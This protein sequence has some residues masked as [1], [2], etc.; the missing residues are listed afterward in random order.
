VSCRYTSPP[1]L[2]LCLC[3]Y[4]CVLVQPSIWSAGGRGFVRRF[5]VVGGSPVYQRGGCGVPLRCG[6]QGQRHRRRAE[7]PRHAAAVAAVAGAPA[8]EGAAGAV[9][10]GVGAALGGARGAWTVCRPCCSVWLF[11]TLGGLF[12]HMA[13]PPPPPPLPPHASEHTRAHA[14]RFSLRCSAVS[15]HL[16]LTRGSLDADP[17]LCF[18]TSWMAAWWPAAACCC[19]AG[20]SFLWGE[21]D[22]LGGSVERPPSL[23]SRWPQARSAA[24]PAGEGAALPAAWRA[25]PAGAPAAA[26]AA[27]RYRHHH[28]HPGGLVAS[29]RQQQPQ[30]SRRRALAC[31]HRSDAAQPQR[32]ALQA[33]W[34]VHRV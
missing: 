26:A 2:C 6:T 20:R 7:L 24:Q 31:A 28:H 9:P 34:C 22:E 15:E 12:V 10:A 8:G 29:A 13:A 3:P 27:A 14:W 32:R 18:L 30:P 1:P 21:L 25:L 11:S 33:R 17:L 4:A 23:L 19:S 5:G 16:R